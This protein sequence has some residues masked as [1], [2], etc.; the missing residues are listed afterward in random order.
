MQTIKL[1]TSL[2]YTMSSKLRQ[3]AVN[4]DNYQALKELG[5][6]GDSFNDVITKVLRKLQR[7]TE[8]TQN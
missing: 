8:D 3:I 5:L 4:E 2:Q 6:A 7:D 1:S